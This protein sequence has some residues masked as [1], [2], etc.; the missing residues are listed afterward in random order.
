[1][2]T[3][4][5]QI[6]ANRYGLYLTKVRVPWRDETRGREGQ[7]KVVE[8]SESRRFRKRFSRT[9]TYPSAHFAV[10]SLV[11]QSSS[12]ISLFQCVLQIVYFVHLLAFTRQTPRVH[13]HVNIDRILFG[14]CGMWNVAISPRVW[15]QAAYWVNAWAVHS[16]QSGQCAVTH[17]IWRRQVLCRQRHFAN[18]A[19]GTMRPLSWA[20]PPVQIESFQP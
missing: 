14:L 16:T 4:W 2:G 15:S 13:I 8:N 3:T 9:G 20:S 11:S 10:R 19:M 5:L 12:V 17:P 18:G 6:P 1:M 7:R